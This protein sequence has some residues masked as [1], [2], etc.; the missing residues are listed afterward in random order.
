M[1]TKELK[2][3]IIDS[4]VDEG[5]SVIESDRIFETEEQFRLA[6]DDILVKSSFEKHEVMEKEISDLK[7]ENEKLIEDFNG[8]CQRFVQER[9][10]YIKGRNKSAEKARKI[11]EL[12]KQIK[13]DPEL[14]N[15]L[16]R[17][18][19]NKKI[20]ENLSWSDLEKLFIIDDHETCRKELAANTNET[21]DKVIAETK[22][23]R[24]CDKYH[25][26]QKSEWTCLDMVISAFSAMKKETKSE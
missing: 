19:R 15:K 18:N 11:Q 20:T 8:V 17:Y 3:M 16:N 6:L 21:L 26:V 13:D 14:I 12:L 9:K 5:L 23:H 7:K 1:N 25:L 22:K 24:N 2:Q 4:F 10:L